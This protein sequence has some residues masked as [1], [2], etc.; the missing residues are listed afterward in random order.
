M[1]PP[2]LMAMVSRVGALGL[3][4]AAQRPDGSGDVVGL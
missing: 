3:D 2:E 1:A 4:D